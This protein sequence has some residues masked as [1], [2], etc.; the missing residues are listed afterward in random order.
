MKKKIARWRIKLSYFSFDIV[1][2]LGKENALADTISRV[3][4]SLKNTEDFLMLHKKLCHL[5]IT[6]M[7]HVFHNQNLPFSIEDVK[8]I[9]NNCQI[10]LVIKLWF[11]KLKP[12][13]L[14]KTTHPFKRLDLDF[15]GP[16]PSKTGN[17]Y[18]LMVV[19]KYSRFCLLFSASAQTVIQDLCSLFSIFRIPAYIHTDQ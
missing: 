18:F 6:R 19:N 11:Y 4:G 13:S 7:L 15:K 12:G 1:Y 16:L 3:C 5:G 10:G 2:C 14:V 9:M 17:R 8:R